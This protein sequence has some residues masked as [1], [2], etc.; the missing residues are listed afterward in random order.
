MRGRKKLTVARVEHKIY[1]DEPLSAE[2]TLLLLDPVKGRIGYGALSDKA[3]E[4]FRAWVNS[5]RTRPTQTQG[6]N[7]VQP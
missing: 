2:V 3:N 1:L 5:M 7:N 6:D 4:L